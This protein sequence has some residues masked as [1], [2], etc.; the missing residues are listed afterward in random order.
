[1]EQFFVA[2]GLPHLMFYYQDH[3][4]TEGGKLIYN[5]FKNKMCWLF[6]LFVIDD[7]LASNQILIWRLF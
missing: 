2:D 6:F 7:K 3:E 5:L 1:M 4:P